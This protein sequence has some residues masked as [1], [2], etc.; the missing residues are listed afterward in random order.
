VVVQLVTPETPIIVQIPAP[1]GALAPVGPVTVAV[2]EMFVPRAADVVFAEA[3]SVGVPFA[4]VV[5]YPEVGA[6]AA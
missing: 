3:A 5:V 1:V 2:K 6:V 4:T